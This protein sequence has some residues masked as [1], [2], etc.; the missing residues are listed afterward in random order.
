MY[1]LLKKWHR[2]NMGN[3]FLQFAI[4]TMERCTLSGRSFYA[5]PERYELWRGSLSKTHSMQE[6]E[7]YWNWWTSQLLFA[8]QQPWSCFQILCMIITH[9]YKIL[10]SRSSAIV[11]DPMTYMMMWEHAQHS[12]LIWHWH[13]PQ[14]CIPV[15]LEG[16]L[17]D[18]YLVSSSLV[19]FTNSQWYFKYRKNCRPNTLWYVS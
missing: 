19:F 9:N 17:H 12:F 6:S 1:F 13:Q 2:E 14:W 16:Q 5:K 18:V 11:R 3:I 7:R 8:A 15:Y 10:C 4:T